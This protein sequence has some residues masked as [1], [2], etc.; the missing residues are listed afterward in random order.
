[1]PT[2]PRKSGKKSKPWQ[3]AASVDRVRR[4]VQL[5]R[6]RRNL[7]APQAPA[8]SARQRI[9]LKSASACT[10]R[11]LATVF[12]SPLIPAATKSTSSSTAAPWASKSTDVKLPDVIADID[13]TTNGHL[14][15]VV[16]THQH[17]DHLSGF[18]EAERS[19]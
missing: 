12:C 7:R 9:Y 3:H 8:P 4:H 11:A 1:M 15:L 13:K 17:Q 14:H 10:G 2:V 18:P 5:L 6:A 19:I 16:A